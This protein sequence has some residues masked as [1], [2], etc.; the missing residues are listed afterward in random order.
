[1]HRLQRS[2]FGRQ[3]HLILLRRQTRHAACLGRG[4]PSMSR[5]PVLCSPVLRSPFSGSPLDRRNDGTVKYHQA[6]PLGLSELAEMHDDWWWNKESDG[7]GRST[8]TRNAGLTRGLIGAICR[9][10]LCQSLYQR[11]L[12]AAEMWLV[13]LAGHSPME[14]PVRGSKRR[15]DVI[16]SSWASSWQCQ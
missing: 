9:P 15:E 10:L 2:W 13:G 12:S 14:R 7:S 1:M 11:P 3:S 8:R 5:S 6:M 16:L 4:E